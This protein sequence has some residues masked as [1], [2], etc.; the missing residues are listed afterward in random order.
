LRE[1]VL[2]E[3]RRNMPRK[4]K[5]YGWVPDLPDH[6]DHLYAASPEILK[7]LPPSMDLRP[8]CPPVYN[9]G[10]LGSCTANA[11]AGAMEFDQKKQGLQEFTPSRLMIHYD[12]RVIE[13]TV[14]SDSG[15]QIRD[16][17]KSVATQGA[18]PETEWPYDITKFADKPP[19]NCY[20]DAVQYRAVSYQRLVQ[21]LT[22]MKGCLTAGYPFVFGFTA[23]E[24]LEQTSP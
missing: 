2:S 13:G 6:R 17:I 14:N 10:D 16:G 22:Q 1:K 12:E 11:I 4:T 20:N 23:Y 21:S 7:A 15:A 3:E 9:H 5:W 19:D 18:C 24:S 8:E